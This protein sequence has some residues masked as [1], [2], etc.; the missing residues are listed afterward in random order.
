MSKAIIIVSGLSRSGT[1]IMMKMLEA[2][3]MELVTDNQRKPDS[4]NP[5]GYYEYEKIRDLRKDS[6][7]LSDFIKVHMGAVIAVIVFLFFLFNLCGHSV[8]HAY[9]GPGAGFAVVS[10]FLILILSGIILPD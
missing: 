8:A 6:S 7:P 4:D 9:I 10:S 1:S 2:R 3:G 5:E